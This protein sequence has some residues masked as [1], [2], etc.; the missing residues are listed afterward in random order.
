M[1][2]QQAQDQSLKH[3]LK[4][5]RLEQS[6]LLDVPAFVIF[7]N[8]VLDR[9]VEL[10]PYDQTSFLEIRGLGPSKWSRYGSGILHV[11]QDALKSSP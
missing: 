7:S 11:I 5:Y 9:L 3:A 4:N 6:R 8:Q 1:T 10:K 2:P